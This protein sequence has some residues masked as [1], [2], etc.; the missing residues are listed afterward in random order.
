MPNLELEKK[1]AALAA[2]SH[3]KNDMVV[4]LGTGSTAKYFIELLC[5]KV[6]SGGLKRI[7]GVCTSHDSR[8]L[9]LAGKLN[10]VSL[11]HIEQIDLAVDGAD[12]VDAK[13][14]SIKGGGGALA[15]EK[16]IAYN[17]KK[18][19]IIADETKYCQK[20]A[21]VT[22]PIEVMEFA[23]PLVLRNFRKMGMRAE[24]R[25]SSGGKIGPVITDN[26]NFLIDAHMDVLDAKKDEMRLKN[27]PGVVEAGIFTKCDLL[28][29]GK[30]KGAQEIKNCRAVF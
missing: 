8:E 18:F 12:S 9:A 26:G 15:R 22:V 14:N 29:I 23:C 2:L 30:E 4:G 24:V 17:A 20:L 7:R 13:L 16:I 3:V 5:E 10:T 1:N 28:I 21:N 11:D 19:I 25:K 27:I 6:R